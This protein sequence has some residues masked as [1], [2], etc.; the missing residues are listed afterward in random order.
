[1]ERN[2]RSLGTTPL[3]SVELPMGSYLVI[4]KKEGYRDTRYPVF[5]SR[6]KAREGSVKLYTDEEIGEGFIHVPVP[7]RGTLAFHE[8]QRL[9][10]RRAR[11]CASGGAT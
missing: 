9:P 8:D 2:E 4:L 1:M 10:I 3:G 11:R 5:I 6:N 7:A